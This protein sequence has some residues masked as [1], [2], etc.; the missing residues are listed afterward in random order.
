MRID[1]I[2]DG[3]I[4]REKG[5]VNHPND[6]GGKT[7]FGI[8]EAVARLNRYAGPMRDM[9]RS[10][11]V[12][13]YRKRY[14]TGPGFDRL[15]PMMPRLADELVDTGVNAGVDR[16]GRMLQRAL[17]LFNRQGRDYPDLVVDANVG[18]ATRAAVAA[19]QRKRGRTA[20]ELL[21]RVLDGFQVEH[22][23]AISEAR[24]TFEDFFTGWI[25][26]RIRNA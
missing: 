2:I 4:A 5:Y 23:A 9:P 6:P 16:A 18:P 1:E 25:A 20:E 19:F 22:Y 14:V 8:T 24:P 26:H 3:V 21:I 15:I 17:N 7:N 10:V 12:D 11:A 13:I